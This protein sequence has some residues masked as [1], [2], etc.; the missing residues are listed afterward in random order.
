MP[1]EEVELDSTNPTRPT[2]WSRS[3]PLLHSG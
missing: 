3:S 1:I 2:K